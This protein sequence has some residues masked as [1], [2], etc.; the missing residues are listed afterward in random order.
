M[1]KWIVR[2]LGRDVPLHFTAFHPD[3]KMIDVPP[4]AGL[5]AAPRARHRAGR[6]HPLRLHRQRPRHRRRH[7]PLPRLRRSAL[8]VRDWHEILDYRLTADGR[9]A[10]CGTAIAGRFDAAPGSSAAGASRCARRHASRSQADGRPNAG[11]ARAKRLIAGATRH[12]VRRR[13]C[14]ARRT[15]AA[16]AS[17]AALGAMRCAWYASRATFTGPHMTT[18]HFRS[19]RRAAAFVV[20]LSFVAAAA[21]GRA[22]RRRHAG[23]DASK[24]SPSTGSPTG[25][26]CCCSPTRRSRRPRSTSPTRSARRTRTTARPA[27]RTCSSTSC[28]RARR[29]AA[30]S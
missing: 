26:P 6:R 24:A 4:H 19:L 21:P 20:E 7:D 16:G 23:P 17:I 15:I 10:A 18:I 8:I 3:Y 2:E 1:S 5:D 9:C 25:S 14:V 22:A 30:T 27:W 11:T 28:S 29:R 13:R 12:F